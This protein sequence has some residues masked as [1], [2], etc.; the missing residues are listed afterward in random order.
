MKT[1][2]KISIQAKSQ[3][4]FAENYAQKHLGFIALERQNFWSFQLWKKLQLQDLN[5]STQD[6]VLNMMNV[7]Y[8]L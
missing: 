1:K 2:Y 4:F 6:K 3:L 7:K 8:I 5:S